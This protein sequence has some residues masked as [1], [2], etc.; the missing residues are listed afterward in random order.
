MNRDNLRL[1]VHDDDL[2][3]RVTREVTPDDLAAMGLVQRP[4]CDE[5]EGHGIDPE[6]YVHATHLEPSQ[7]DPCP[8][9]GGSGYGRLVSLDVN[10]EALREIQYSTAKQ[11]D[12]EI[13]VRPAVLVGR[14][15]EVVH[16]L[17]RQVLAALDGETS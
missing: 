4:T 14:S 1:C 11:V 17:I 2:S 3:W 6:S 16:D 15:A 8:K 12:P 7:A 13:P 10:V 5:C 9:C